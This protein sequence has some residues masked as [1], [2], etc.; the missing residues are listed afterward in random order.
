MKDNTATNAISLTGINGNINAKSLITPHR[1]VAFI[2]PTGDAGLYA[3]KNINSSAW[4]PAVCLDTYSGGHW[5]IGN[6]A[7]EMLQFVYGTK[8]NRD[9]GT[10]RTFRCFIRPGNADETWYM[11]RLGTII[12]QPTFTGKTTY[13]YTG[14]SVEPPSNEIWIVR[15][16]FRYVNAA[17]VEVGVHNS[18]NT[19]NEWN[20]HDY[21]SG[22]NF[23]L[24]FMVY[25]GEKL[26]YWA[27][28]GGTA[29]NRIDQV[30]LRLQY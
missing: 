2:N 23:T 13:S 6:Y 3:K 16:Y 28:C 9:S 7:D 20:C 5:Q 25:G 30:I 14:I 18:S 21:A 29:Q 24:N 15:A 27:R 11:P 8:A 19:G 1:S 17:L 4:Y 12:N 10:N 26:Y 22:K